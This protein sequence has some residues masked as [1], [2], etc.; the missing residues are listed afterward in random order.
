MGEVYHVY[1]GGWV[2]IHIYGCTGYRQIWIYFR[3]KY[4]G[5]GQNFYWLMNYWILIEDIESS[6]QVS[7]GFTHSLYMK[8]TISGG[9]N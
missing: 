6:Y 3:K 1:I 5:F 8:F 4:Q 7:G 9:K 2:T